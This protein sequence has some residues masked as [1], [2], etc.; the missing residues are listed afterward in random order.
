MLPHSSTQTSV[1]RKSRR[2]RNER[3]NKKRYE[4]CAT[5]FTQQSVC[6]PRLPSNEKAGS[7]NLCR[8]AQILN[9]AG[10]CR[11]KSLRAR[12]RK[13]CVPHRSELFCCRF[14]FSR[15]PSTDRKSRVEETAMRIR[16][17]LSG[18]VRYG[19]YPG[20]KALD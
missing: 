10:Q 4:G 15:E 13:D 5:I 7:P 2:T 18:K 16:D 11:L 19:A 9:S 6:R 1:K 3:T 20:K 14:C 12:S 17:V 8:G